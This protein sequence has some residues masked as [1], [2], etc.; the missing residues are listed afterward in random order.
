MR[1][2]QAQKKDNNVLTAV[3][4]RLQRRLNQRKRKET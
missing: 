2:L 1:D 4:P 3:Q